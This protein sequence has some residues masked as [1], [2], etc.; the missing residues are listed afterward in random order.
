M[1]IGLI[2]GLGQ[3]LVQASSSLL[4]AKEDERKRAIEEED[5]AK[6]NKLFELQ[7]KEQQRKT[8]QEQYGYE[9]GAARLMDFLQTDAIAGVKKTFEPYN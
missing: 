4:Q 3:G 2:G 6:R 8:T 9:E 1:A 5:R 7:M